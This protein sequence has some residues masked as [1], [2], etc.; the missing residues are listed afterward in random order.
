MNRTTEHYT[1]LEVGFSMFLT[2][3]YGCVWQLPLNQH[4]DDAV[5]LLQYLH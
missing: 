2:F 3:M 1:V 5:L 4:V